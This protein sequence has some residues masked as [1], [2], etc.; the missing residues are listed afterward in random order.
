MC[1]SFCQS[2]RLQTWNFL[3]AGKDHSFIA[4]WWCIIGI[5]FRRIS[6]NPLNFGSA[7]YTQWVGEATNF[8][9]NGRPMASAMGPCLGRPIPILTSKKKSR[10]TIARSFHFFS[11]FMALYYYPIAFL[12]FFLLKKIINKYCRHRTLQH[13]EKCS[14]QLLKSVYLHAKKQ[15]CGTH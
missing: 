9:W 11:F 13:S 15:K 12:S 14:I 1:R 2:C 5:F 7:S 10:R 8:W 4:A 3:G 6:V